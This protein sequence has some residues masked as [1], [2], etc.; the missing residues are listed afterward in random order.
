MGKFIIFAL[1]RS[2]TAWLSFFLSYQGKR[3]G[4]DIALGCKT[5]EDFID[6]F[7]KLDGT[8]ETG[9][10]EGWEEI[11]KLAGVR[12]FVIKR[13]LNEVADSL[14]KLSILFDLEQLKRREKLLQEVSDYDGTVTFAYKDLDFTLIMKYLFTNCLNLPFD[15]KW[16]NS[17]KKQNIQV[18]ISERLKLIGDNRENTAI[19]KDSLSDKVRYRNEGFETSYEE[20][21]RLGREHFEE[22]DGGVE[23]RR[24]YNLDI[25]LMRMAYKTGSMRIMTARLK[26]ELV[27]YFTWNVTKDIESKGLLIAQQ[28]AWF[29]KKDTGKSN[30]GFKLFEFSVG[31]LKKLGVKLI[32]PH[33]RMQ[34]R[35][36][37]LGKFFIRLGAIET[38]RTYSLWIGG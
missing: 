27:G 19:L 35:G 10:V 26:G 33:H 12:F 29:V 4:H 9:A 16:Y 8:V 2:R 17:L 24:A 7:E 32:F 21:E 11:K 14:T 31:E 15:Y 30:I 34:G 23:P 1:P 38:Q 20:G 36:K 22:V 18:D 37:N 5:R 6:R 3:V 13:P 25:D 28:G